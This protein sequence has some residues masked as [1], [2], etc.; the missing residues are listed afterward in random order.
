MSSAVSFV[1]Q[2]SEHPTPSPAAAR[3]VTF[4][5]GAL[6]WSE[7]KA[8]TTT[9]VCVFNVK[10]RYTRAKQIFPSHEHFRPGRA[11]T[12]VNVTYAARLQR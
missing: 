10:N 4:P 1:T 2:V 9:M 5:A 11:A 12:V 8:L 6:G 3:R 7:E